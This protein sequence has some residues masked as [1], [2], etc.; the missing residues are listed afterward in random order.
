MNKYCEHEG[1]SKRHLQMVAWILV[2][3]RDLFS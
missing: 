2:K 3:A 1:L